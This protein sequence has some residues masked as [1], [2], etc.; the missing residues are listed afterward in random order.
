MSKY[1]CLIAGLPPV[2]L[3]DTRL[4]Y[5]VSDFK[6]TLEVVLSEADKQLIRW[7]F[8][9]Y[10]HANLLGYLRRKSI[11]QWDVRAVYSAEEIKEVCDLMKEEDRVPV[12]IPIP[13]YLIAF[14]RT[15]YARFEEAETTLSQRLEDHLA[16][17]Y[18]NEAMQCENKF[19]AEWS[20]MNLNIGN[21]MTAANCRKYGL[22]REA[23]IIGNNETAERLRRTNVRDIHPGDIFESA[24]ELMQIAEEP[25]FMMREKRQD[26]LRWKWLDEHTFFK[27]FDIES[28]MAYLLR[29]E[30]TER[31]IALDKTRGEQTFRRLVSDMKRE[32]VK[33]LEEFKENNK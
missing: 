26:V 32:S 4:A 25:D 31:W 15:Y 28:V 22:D 30:M 7:L 18:Y 33:T 13:I 19:L 17:L 24:S 10:D 21:V 29:L 1:Y 6:A 11:E 23:Y 12:N 20:G 14:I 5:S 27:T 16:T 8:Y 3:D 2:T 9:P